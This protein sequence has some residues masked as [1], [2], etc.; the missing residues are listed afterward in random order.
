MVQYIGVFEY[1]L[2]A[3]SCEFLIHP[4]SYEIGKVIYDCRRLPWGINGNEIKNKL[5]NVFTSR[6][7]QK[8]G[9][10]GYNVLAP[11][12]ENSLY[13]WRGFFRDMLFLSNEGLKQL[14]QS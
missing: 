3:Y 8:T 7:T 5:I 6:V 12:R 14:G 10:H 4:I 13:I 1:S 9:Y 11:L 2:I